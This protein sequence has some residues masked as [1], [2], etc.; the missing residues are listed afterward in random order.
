MNYFE[1][2]RDCLI[3]SRHLIVFSKGDQ[4][5]IAA[6]DNAVRLLLIAGKPIGESVAWYGPIVI[7]TQEV[8]RIA[9]S[10]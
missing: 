5:E 2:E 6:A 10:W 7:S 3:D 9:P 4:L 8:L 1:V